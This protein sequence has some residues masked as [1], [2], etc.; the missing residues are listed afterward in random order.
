MAREEMCCRQGK[1]NCVSL[2]INTFTSP[3]KGDTQM[4]C[5]E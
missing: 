1:L 4:F 2:Q 5:E 3:L